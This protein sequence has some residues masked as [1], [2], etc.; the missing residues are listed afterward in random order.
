MMVAAEM[1]PRFQRCEH[2]VDDRL[3]GIVTPALPPRVG[4]P[5]AA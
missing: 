3:A 2:L 1:Q 4:L 5:R